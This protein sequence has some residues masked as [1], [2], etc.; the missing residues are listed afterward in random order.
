MS[1]GVCHSCRCLFDVAL[2]ERKVGTDTLESS[3]MG[4]CTDAVN[5]KSMSEL[6]M[7][8]SLLI[9]LSIIE[10]FLTHPVSLHITGKVLL[11]EAI[12]GAL[13]L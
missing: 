6:S 7:Y 1:T 9:P 3:S 8:V 13:W 4:E 12:G 5:M 11:R 10:F 2:S